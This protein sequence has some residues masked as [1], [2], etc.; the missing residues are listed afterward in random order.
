MDKW[1][2]VIGPVLCGAIYYGIVMSFYTVE[3]LALG[4]KSYLASFGFCTIIVILFLY[5]NKRIHKE[6]FLEI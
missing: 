2:I 5:M 4:N 1:F 3:E 6:V